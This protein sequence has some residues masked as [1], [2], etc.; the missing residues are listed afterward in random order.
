MKNG[1]FFKISHAYYSL[2]FYTFSRMT[3]TAQT[4]NANQLQAK[5]APPQAVPVINYTARG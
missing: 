2:L 1:I 5:G 3:E 4:R